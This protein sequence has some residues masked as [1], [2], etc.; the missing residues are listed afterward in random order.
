MVLPDPPGFWYY[1]DP[2][3]AKKYQMMI[4]HTLRLRHIKDIV[5]RDG[6]L[7]EQI[8]NRVGE[9]FSLSSATIDTLDATTM[10]MLLSAS[11]YRLL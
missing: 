4:L 8:I 10:S 2:Q 3:A 11:G 1:Y 7:Q 6:L 5:I 9:G